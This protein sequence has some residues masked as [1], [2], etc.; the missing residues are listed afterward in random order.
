[1]FYFNLNVKGLIGS[2]SVVKEIN[3]G[4]RG[5]DNIKGRKGNGAGGKGRGRIL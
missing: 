5:G 3:I 2:I 4:G 1:M